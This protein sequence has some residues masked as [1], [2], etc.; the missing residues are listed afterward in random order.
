MPG[1]G[2]SGASRCSGR[3]SFRAGAGTE[4]R[5]RGRVPSSLRRQVS[6]DRAGLAVR[7]EAG[8]PR[9]RCRSRTDVSGS[10]GAECGRRRRAEP[11]PEGEQQAASRW[12]RRQQRLSPRAGQRSRSLPSRTLAGREDNVRCCS[13]PLP[14]PQ[15]T[16]DNVRYVKLEHE[17]RLGKPSSLCPN[18]VGILGQSLFSATAGGN[19]GGA[20]RV[21]LPGEE[22]ALQGRSRAESGLLAQGVRPRPRHRGR[23]C[24]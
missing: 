1:T 4:G 5:A 17:R 13:P 6:L 15:Q 8:C 21:G 11:A 12:R 23:P 18:P 22:G 24:N 16:H 14:E 20:A 9:D 3:D 2:L 10:L 19:D 7:Q